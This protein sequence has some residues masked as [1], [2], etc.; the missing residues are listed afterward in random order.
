MIRP[1]SDIKTTATIKEK[2]A[3]QKLSKDHSLFDSVSLFSI[4][5]YHKNSFKI[6]G[7]NGCESCSIKYFK[8]MME[9]N[10][11]R[12]TSNMKTQSTQS[13]K[14]IFNDSFFIRKP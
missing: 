13:R 7:S 6:K 1:H 9:S 5:Y 10:C 12:K 14:E 2:T 11:E 3:H 4:K 8:T